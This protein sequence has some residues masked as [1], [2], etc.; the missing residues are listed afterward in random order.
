MEA[1]KDLTG[2]VGK[3]A[4]W[5]ASA[6]LLVKA[7]GFLYLLIV[8][9][10]LTVFE[11]GVAELVITA[12]PLLSFF[13]LPGLQTTVVADMGRERAAGNLPRMKGLAISYL[14]LQYFFAVFAWAAVFFGAHL[15]AVWYGKGSTVLLFQII[16]FSFL[17]SPLR[18][19]MQA[20]QSVF[21]AFRQ[22]SVYAFLEECW[23]LILVAI[24]FFVLGFRIG[25]LL[26]AVVLSQVFALLTIVRFFFMLSPD[27][28]AASAERYPVFH[29]LYHHGKWG[30]LSNYT[31]TFGKNVR[32]WI[33]NFILGP[34]AVGVFAVAQ[35]LIGHTLSLTPLDTVIK[36]IL[37]QYVHMK[38]RFYAL[39]AKA[40]KYELFGYVAAGVAAAIGVPFLVHWFFP[41]YVSAVSLFWIMLLALI[42]AAFDAIFSGVFFALQAQRNLFWASVYKLFLIFVLLPPSVYLFGLF[43]I[44]YANIFINLLYVWERYL[45]LKRL[46]PEF[47]LRLK[48]I[49]TVDETDK[50][51]IKRTLK[52]IGRI[53]ILGSMIRTL[54]FTM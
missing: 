16:S 52:V 23:K 11:Y 1:T 12:V 31:G 50:I 3:G 34:Q 43:G 22:Q 5:T 48:Y 39:I 53:P 27:F 41:Q 37:P 17:I 24:L 46:M 30:V 32:P 14:K 20:V 44:A 25:G 10:H 13:Q 29:F 8:L 19:T 38:E 49:M 47:S 40:V 45:K 36:P 51:I 35:G 4:A 42:P 2:V 21:F 28:F 15:L 9:N 6:T 33:I 7:V 18:N 54:P 26:V